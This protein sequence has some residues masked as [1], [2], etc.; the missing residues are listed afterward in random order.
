MLSAALASTSCAPMVQKHYR[1]DLK[2]A[3]IKRGCGEPVYDWGEFPF[4]GIRIRANINRLHQWVHFELP[5]GYTVR[6]KH[7]SARFEQGPRNTTVGW[8]DLTR[9]NGHT[10][11]DS[12][13]EGSTSAARF[14]FFK[15]QVYKVYK[16]SPP[17]HVPVEG[18]KIILV[19]PEMEI[20]GVTHPPLRIPFKTKHTFRIVPMNGC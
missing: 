13:M 16:L 10:L 18:G 4:H 19:L 5:E 12:V 9:A 7:F 11:P 3:E 17:K 14:L 6:L 20:N 15:W 2:G 1:M 8:F